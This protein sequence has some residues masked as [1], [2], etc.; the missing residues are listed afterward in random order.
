MRRA[1]RADKNQSEIVAAYRR[2]GASVQ[3]LHT[4]GQG[5]PDLLVGIGGR[6]GEG[7]LNILVEVKHGKG[8]LTGDEPAWHASWT[9]QVEIVDFVDKAVKRFEHWRD[10]ADLLWELTQNI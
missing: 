4:I 5:C 2:L 10:V 9:G 3:H 6:S 7:G 8:K 1:A